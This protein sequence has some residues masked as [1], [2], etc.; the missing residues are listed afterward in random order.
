MSKSTDTHSAADQS[1]MVQ[2][3]YNLFIGSKKEAAAPNRADLIKQKQ[4]DIIRRRNKNLNRNR[5]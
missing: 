3:L 1:Q 4:A 5:A 2:E